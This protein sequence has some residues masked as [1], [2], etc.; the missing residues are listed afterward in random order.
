MDNLVQ[1]G[2][3]VKVTAPTGGYANG[4]FVILHTDLVG[5]VNEAVGNS[6]VATL[7]VEGVYNVTTKVA[8]AAN[9]WAVGDPV[10]ITSTGDFTEAATGNHYAGRA[11]EAAATGATTGKVRINFG[12]DPT[13]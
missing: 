4:A 1:N 5:V 11:W 13:P 10:Y 7:V 3:T 6:E 12:V 9:D 2:E 8:S